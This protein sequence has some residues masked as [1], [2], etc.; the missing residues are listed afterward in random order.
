MH[1]PPWE[2]CSA[3]GALVGFGIGV[4]F[5]VVGAGLSVRIF[6][7]ERS[8]YKTPGIEMPKATISFT[9]AAGL[10][11]RPSNILATIVRKHDATATITFDGRTADMSSILDIMSLGVTPGEVVVETTGKDADRLLEKVEQ[12]FAR[13]FDEF[14]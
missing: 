13:N 4:A 10:H 9:H 2:F 14:N 3:A 6:N 5:M 7:L 11:C 1:A 12:V 8:S